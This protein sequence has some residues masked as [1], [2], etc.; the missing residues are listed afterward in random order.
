M[1]GHENMKSNGCANCSGVNGQDW[2]RKEEEED[3]K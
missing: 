3:D 2:Y 1:N